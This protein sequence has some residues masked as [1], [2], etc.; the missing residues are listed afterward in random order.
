[1]IPAGAANSRGAVPLR[2]KSG[3]TPVW[4]ITV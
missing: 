3:A 2:G 1:M 4:S